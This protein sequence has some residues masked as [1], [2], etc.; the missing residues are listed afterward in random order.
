[1]ALKEYQWTE[2]FIDVRECTILAESLEDAME[3]RYQ[4]DWYDEVT[5]EFYSNRLIKEMELVDD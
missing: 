2:E 1:M 3:K 5:V 4:G